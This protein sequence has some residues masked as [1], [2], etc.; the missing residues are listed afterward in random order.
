[1]PRKYERTTRRTMLKGCAAT[2]VGIGALSGTGVAQ[3]GGNRNPRL[4]LVGHTTLGAPDGNITNMDVREDLGLA[5][6]G[7]FVNADTEVHIADVSDLEN[8]EHVTTTSVG[9]GYVNDV[10]FHPTEPWVFTA[11]EGGPDAGWSILDVDDPEEPEL[12]GP[13]D[14]EGGAGVHTIIAF[15]EEHVIVSGTGRGIVIYDVTDPENPRDIGDFQVAHEGHSVASTSPDD[16]GHTHPSGYVHDTQVRGD[17]VYLANWDHGL[18]ILDLSEPSNPAVAASFDY[19]EEDADVPLRNA[20]H[21]FPH[22]EDDICILGEEVGSGE[23]G[24]KH[25]IEFDLEAGETERLSSFRPP[26]GSAQQPTG[27]QGFWW[28]G[29]FSDW[30]VGDQQDVLF[31]G[32]YKAGV[33]TFDLSDPA[34]PERIDQY[35]TTDGADEVRQADPARS[36]DAIPQVWGA[37]TKDSEYVYVSD[38]NTGLFVFTLEGY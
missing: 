12:Y 29:H 25:V 26:Q 32:D 16:P 24:Y 20:H 6:T 4:E 9:V 30:G 34:N 2:A 38:A 8:P 18:Y 22:P 5:A 21:A 7:S 3:D 11:N 28:T 36:I 17:Y 15:D 35:M 27:Q 37:N 1:M 13:F 23:P 31:S 33:Q 10:F 14:V 19:Q